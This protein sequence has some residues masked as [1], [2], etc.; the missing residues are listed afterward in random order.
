MLKLF[1]YFRSYVKESVLAPLFKLAE[2]LLDLL[3]PL[4]IAAIIDDGI[5]ENNN[6]YIVNACVFLLALAALGLLLSVTAQYF[7]A[8]AA[9]GYSSELRKSLFRHIE[10]LDLTG[11]DYIGSG[12]LITRMTNDVN[13]VQNGVN[14]A[15]RLF[16]RAPVIVIG[17]VIAS[18]TIDVKIALIFGGFV[19]LLSVVIFSIMGK[20]I[21]LYKKSNE[22]L[23]DVLNAVKENLAG[24]R[25]LRAFSMERDEIENFNRVNEKL[26]AFQKFSGKI[27]AILNPA[28]YVIINISIILLIYTGS[29]KVYQGALTK[30]SVVALYNYMSGTLLELIKFADLII[31]VSKGAS[32]LKRIS[33][34]FDIEPSFNA[35]LETAGTSSGDCAVEFKNVGLTYKGAG[36]ASL[37]NINFKIKKGETLGIVGPVGS[38]KTSLVNLIARFYTATEGEILIDG[39]PI[40]DYSENDLRKK[41]SVVPQKSVLFSGT[42]RDNLKWGKLDASDN[43]I[44]GCLKT[45]AALDIVEK[46]KDGLS[47]CIEEDGKNLSGGQRQRLCIARALLKNPEI[48]IFDDSMSALDYSTEFYLKK[49][50]KED[51]KDTTLVIISGRIGSVRDADKIIVLDEGKQEGLGTDSEL[52]SSCTLYKEILE[53]S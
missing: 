37:S 41:I 5:P 11:I 16:L 34:V 27:S 9:S 22:K 52:L 2:A 17:S 29:L 48:L 33:K 25:V 1:K 19:V 43:E 24:T 15:L 10:S 8:K 36:G 28:T 46:K 7:A 31:N 53:S 4:V 44:Y 49:A 40:N 45:A 38:G 26:T 39:I 50:L 13:Q 23:D 20:C 47:Y 35:P 30:G 21:S 14:L 12:T 6:V 42:L 51:Y 3:V 18:F 32:G